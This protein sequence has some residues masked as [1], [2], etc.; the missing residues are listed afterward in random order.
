M[1]PCLKNMLLYPNIVLGKVLPFLFQITLRQLAER[2]GGTF[3]CYSTACE[4]SLI[5]I[6]EKTEL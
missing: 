3:H 1:T 6:L 4:V 5:L 2:N